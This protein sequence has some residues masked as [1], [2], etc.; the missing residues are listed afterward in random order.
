LA[1]LPIRISK[2]PAQTAPGFLVKM[3]LDVTIAWIWI[4]VGALVSALGIFLAYRRAGLAATYIYAG[5]LLLLAASAF[6][7]HPALLRSGLPQDVQALQDALTEEKRKASLEQGGFVT[8]KAKLTKLEQSANATA[9]ELAETK[10]AAAACLSDKEE[11]RGR[12]TGLQTRIDN[13]EAEIDSY[14]KRLLILSSGNKALTEQLEA[15]KAG[16][17]SALQSYQTQK[18]LLDANLA[19]L[20]RLE[21]EKTA[22]AKQLA[23][24]EQQTA[25]PLKPAGQQKEQ[26]ANPDTPE[27]AKQAGKVQL[28]LTSSPRLDIRKLENSELVQGET[29]DYYLIGPKDAQTGSPI[30]FPPAQF[31]IT[32]KADQ[33]R[34]AMEELR[35]AVLQRIPPDWRY[36]I[37]VRG[38]A[39][40]GSFKEPIGDEAYRNL[41]FLPPGDSPGSSY[42]SQ[43]MRKYLSRNFENADLPNLRGVFLA[44]TLQASIRGE[45]PVLLGN[46]PGTGTDKASRRADIVLLLKRPNS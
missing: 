14:R 26:A 8:E 20:R 13:Y 12:N 2:E 44:R 15:E 29:G 24:K 3:A 4:L 32:D 43:A 30:I 23:A 5:G 40:G 16:H 10:A 28:A 34:S 27:P 17:R 45:L 36:R 31:I 33:L 41:E 9:I 11:Q 7:V 37:F 1:P 35:E 22:L 42:R 18:T 21:A 25:G 6:R 46:A 39:D 38:Y 19:H